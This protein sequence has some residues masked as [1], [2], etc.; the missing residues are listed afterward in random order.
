MTK[1]S[2]TQ[3]TVIG[4]EL[5]GTPVPLLSVNEKTIKIVRNTSHQICLSWTVQM[6]I[7]L[8]KNRNTLHFTE[9]FCDDLMADLND[10]KGNLILDPDPNGCRSGRVKALEDKRTKVN[11]LL[12]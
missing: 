1:K 8:M 7:K 4:I 5:F 12:F 2:I 3:T 10:L 6:V 9:C 11:Q